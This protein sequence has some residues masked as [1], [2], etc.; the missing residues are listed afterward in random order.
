MLLLHLL[1]CPVVL[2]FA[3]NTYVYGLYFSQMVGLFFHNASLG[4]FLDR[5]LV[6]GVYGLH[7]FLMAFPL[8]L[9]C[10]VLVR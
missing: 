8:C 10:D 6:F 2:G 5:F 4:L 1:C 7:V 3:L 9:P